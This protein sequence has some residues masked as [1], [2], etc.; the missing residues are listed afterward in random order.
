VIVHEG[1]CSHASDLKRPSTIQAA[2]EYP[3]YALQIELLDSDARDEFLRSIAQAA[4]AGGSILFNDV[5]LLFDPYLSLG[6]VHV[7]QSSVIRQ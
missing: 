5:L 2:Y 1:S 4:A 6:C 7:Q 3:A